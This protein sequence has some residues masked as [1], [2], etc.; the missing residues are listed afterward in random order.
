VTLFDRD[1]AVDYDRFPRRA[2]R[3]RKRDGP[4]VAAMTG[5]SPT[6]TDEESSSPDRPDEGERATVIA[7]TGT[8]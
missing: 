3:D 6:L 8:Y 5:E 7:S 1:G 4:V 2:A